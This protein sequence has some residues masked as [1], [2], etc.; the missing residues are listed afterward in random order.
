[1]APYSVYDKPALK[2][3]KD[4]QTIEDIKFVEEH[5]YIL[6][7]SLLEPELVASALE[8]MDRLTGDGAK[9]GRNAFEGTAASVSTFSFPQSRVR[10]TYSADLTNCDSSRRLIPDP[11]LLFFHNSKPF[12]ATPS[13]HAQPCPKV[14]TPTPPRNKHKQDL[15]PPQ[16]IPHL[17]PLHHHSAR[18]R[19]KRLFPR[20]W[21]PTHI[22][23]YHLRK[24]RRKR[25]GTSSR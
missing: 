7:P 15:L 14:N 6:F 3:P 8:E 25:P 13:S 2:L 11:I 16:Q 22:F 20:R 24:S 19:S 23:P 10:F 5:G 9:V 4:N 17:R 1:M 18:P 21:L 12:L